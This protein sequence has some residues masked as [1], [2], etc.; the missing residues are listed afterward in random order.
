MCIN[1][2]V[3]TD[4]L[5]G[6]SFASGLKLCLTL[7]TSSIIKEE[8]AMA[9]KVNIYVEYIGD[10][11]ISAAKAVA[12]NQRMDVIIH[13][14]GVTTEVTYEEAKKEKGDNSET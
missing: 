14:P 7:M 11:I 2:D 5:N 13:A 4:F 9:K 1:K 8:K 6:G 3:T 12:R 10:D